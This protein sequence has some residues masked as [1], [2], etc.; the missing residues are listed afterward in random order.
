MSFQRVWLLAQEA[1]GA[2]P[3]A[4]LLNFAPII[5]IGV[6]AY[7]ML[8]RPHQRERAEMRAML[9]NLQKDDRV[10]TI[11]GIFGTVV[12]VSKDAEDITLKVDENGN[13]R[14]RVLRSAISRVIKD[15]AKDAKPS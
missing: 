11:G 1:G 2:D 9:E 3:L 15:D 4:G 6:L 10:V 14:I 7:F 8:F 13:T 12:N 5:V